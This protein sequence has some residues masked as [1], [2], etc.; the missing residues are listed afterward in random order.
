[1]KSL[2]NASRLSCG[3]KRRR[4]AS[5]RPADAVGWRTNGILPY[6]AAPA[7]SKRLLGSGSVSAY[8]LRGLWRL[9]RAR[10]TCRLPRF[11]WL[12]FGRR[13]KVNPP[14]FR[15]RFWLGLDHCF[16]CCRCLTNRASAAARRRTGARKLRIHRV[17]PGHKPTLPRFKRRR[18]LQ[19]QVRRRQHADLLRY[20]FSGHPHHDRNPF[21]AA[22]HAGHPGFPDENVNGWPTGVCEAHAGTDD[23]RNLDQGHRVPAVH[24]ERQVESRLPTDDVRARSRD[25]LLRSRASPAG[26]PRERQRGR[27]EDAHGRQGAGAPGKGAIV[28]VRWPR[29]S[30]LSPVEATR[31]A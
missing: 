9:W 24:G 1:M 17:S 13:R 23:P 10:D 27:G 15:F 11:R 20:K 28:T 2:P 26:K 30:F 3:R 29:E 18:Q 22:R 6:S 4:R 31:Q 21:Q 5:A 7:S 8:R 16:V 25:C 19:A 12:R 14:P